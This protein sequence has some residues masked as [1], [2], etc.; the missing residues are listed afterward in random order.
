MAFENSPSL[1]QPSETRPSSLK[2]RI[3]QNRRK[4]IMAG[5]I[6]AVLWLAGTGALFLLSS[7]VF[8]PPGGAEGY[9]VTPTGQ[10]AQALIT[11]SDV[12]VRTYE[13]GYFFF[14][15]LRPGE[16]EMIIETTYG[17]WRQPVII[18]SDQAVDLG[19]IVLR[20]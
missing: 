16:H 4:W 18:I 10:P 2:D 8:S 9:L 13:D 5:V 12:K 19:K 14:P 11:I 15:E 3:Y 17:V 6:F 1:D 7:N 20:K